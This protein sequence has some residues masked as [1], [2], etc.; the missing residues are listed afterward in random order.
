MDVVL[1]KSIYLG[2]RPVLLI[3]LNPVLHLFHLLAFNHLTLN[4]YPKMSEFSLMV[5]IG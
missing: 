1:L 2:I 4:Q 5:L 3:Y